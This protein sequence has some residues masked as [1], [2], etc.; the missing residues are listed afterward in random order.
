MSRSQ[1]LVEH[2]M[3]IILMNFS[4]INVGYLLFQVLHCIDLYKYGNFY[5]LL[6]LSETSI[7]YLIPHFFLL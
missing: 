1:T 2:L 3:S 5:K 4:C 7:S 6:P